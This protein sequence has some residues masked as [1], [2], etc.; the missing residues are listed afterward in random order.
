MLVRH[1][2]SRR[3]ILLRVLT[4]F[5]ECT[6]DFATGGSAGFEDW[7]KAREEILSQHELL[8]LMPRWVGLQPVG[9]PVLAIHEGS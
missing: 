5:Q 8:P 6:V 1:Q 2:G 7:E 3:E 9:K 4:A